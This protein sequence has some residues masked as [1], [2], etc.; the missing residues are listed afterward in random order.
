IADVARQHVNGRGER[1]PNGCERRRGEPL[2]SLGQLHGEKRRAGDHQRQQEPRGPELPAH[3]AT[4]PETGRGGYVTGLAGGCNRATRPAASSTTRHAGA[5][6]LS[7]ARLI[8]PVAR[9]FAG[10]D[11]GNPVRTT[12]LRKVDSIPMPRLPPFAR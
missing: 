12:G 8:L 10:N 5:S 7:T 9:P 1:A 2:V 3:V 4:S 6:A 11:H